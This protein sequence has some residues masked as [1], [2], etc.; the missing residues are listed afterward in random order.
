MLEEILTYSS[1]F[2]WL[3]FKAVSPYCANSLMSH[4]IVLQPLAIA[5][6]PYSVL[7][8]TSRHSRSWTAFVELWRWW[9]T[10]SQSLCLLNN[11]ESKIWN[12]IFLIFSLNLIWSCLFSIIAFAFAIWSYSRQVE[13]FRFVIPVHYQ[14]C[15]IL[16]RMGTFH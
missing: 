15:P 8:V 10:S 11:Y 16:Y 7:V 4:T 2:H 5:S 9:T 13:P 12:F 1:S 14:V 3:H 6:I